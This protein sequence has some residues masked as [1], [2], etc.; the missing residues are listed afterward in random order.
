MRRTGVLLAVVL[1]VVL[2]A[3]TS[4]KNFAALPKPPVTTA[5][6]TTTTTEPDLSAVS[7][8][9]VKG[10]T[11]TSVA[12]GPGPMTIVGT[13]QGPDG[14]IPDAVVQLD[15]LVGD[16]VA[17]TRVPTA[18][19]GTWNVQHVLGGRYRIRAWRAPDLATTTPQIVFIESGPQRV[20]SVHLDP[21]GGLRV[22][23]AIAP[24]PPVVNRPANLKVRVADRSVDG[25]GVVRDTPRP[26]M[27][28]TLVGGGEWSVGSPNPS[29]TDGDGSAIFRV[30]CGGDGSQSLSAQLETGDTYPLAIPA[31]VLANATTS[32]TGS[33]SSTTTTT[34]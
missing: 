24:D 21:V 17:S 20:V 27:S 25:D 3:C 23:D 18:P 12:I 8:P 10:T 14:A 26:G 6:S 4:S 34:R 28:V 31:C 33:S 11:S 32:T 2:A 30:T 19:D 1:S 22:D 15:R 7:L 9:R 5:E 13:V 29:T 16:G